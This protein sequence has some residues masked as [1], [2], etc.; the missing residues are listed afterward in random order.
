MGIVYQAH[1]PRFGREVAIKMLPANLTT[2]D[3]SRAR[4]E[5][6]A[7][8]IA[9]LGHSCIVP[10]HDYGEHEGQPYLVMSYMEGESLAERLN[11][12]SLSTK[13]AVH[14]LGRVARALDAAHDRAIIHRDV[15]PANILFDRY[16]DAFLSDF[17]I[18][19]L[20]QETTQLT[21]PGAIG[22]PHYMAPEMVEKVDLTNAIDVYA[23][24]VTLY[25]MLTGE[26]P[27]DAD[28]ARRIILAHMT[29]PIPDVRVRRPDLPAG[30]TSV[31]N[32]GMAKDAQERYPSAGELAD[33]FDYA[34]NSGQVSDTL[35][36]E[37]PPTAPLVEPTEVLPPEPQAP[38]SAHPVRQA[39]P[40]APPVRER[41]AAPKPQPKRQA[42]SSRSGL[43]FGFVVLV[44]AVVAGIIFLPGLLDDGSQLEDS[45]TTESAQ[46]VAELPTDEPTLAPG[47]TSTEA[48]FNP[49]LSSENCAAASVPVEACTGVARNSEWT[50]YTRDF[51]GV[52]MALVPAGCFMMGSEDGNPDEAPVHEVCFETPF[53]IDVYEVTNAQHGSSGRFE[54]TTQPRE[55]ILWEDALT[56]CAKRGARLPTEAEWEYAAR[57]PD[58]LTYPWGNEFV[59]GNV[60]YSGNSGGQTQPIGSR[61]GGV[62]WV[63][64]HDM[65]GNVWEWVAD[66]H[67]SAYYA[68]SPAV[69]PQGPDDGEFHVLRGGS[70]INDVPEELTSTLRDKSSPVFTWDLDGFRCARSY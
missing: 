7:R 2:D 8:T 1:D 32:K 60:V 69:N 26:V 22:T 28:S 64:A 55:S 63:G 33:A 39:R 20:T 56:Q 67:D 3:T 62:S 29:Q 12:G 23:L 9:S 5:R 49:S 61:P 14:I 44:L 35:L 57:G 68:S 15:K 36:S 24:A 52:E 59:G 10:V 53:F 37:D 47:V 46:E 34:V 16:D 21:G 27:Y 6:E 18:V 58:G 17:G 25:H 50:P 41:P 54:G 4:F 65:S 51:S 30:V 42:S 13:T 40:V 48:A 66:W 31:I 43:W 19:K 45:P 38:P 11:T 70:W